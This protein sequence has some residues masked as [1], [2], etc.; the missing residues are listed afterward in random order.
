MPNHSLHKK[1][2][3]TQTTIDQQASLCCCYFLVMLP[4]LKHKYNCVHESD[5]SLHMLQ[6]RLK[7]YEFGTPAIFGSV[8]TFR[9]EAIHLIHKASDSHVIQ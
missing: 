4:V 2:E 7:Y 5:P 9:V 1:I 6:Q 8:R 3:E